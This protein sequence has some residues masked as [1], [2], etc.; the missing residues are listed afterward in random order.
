MGEMSL[1]DQVNLGGVSRHET[2]TP[3]YGWL[4]KGFEASRQDAKVFSS[5]DAIER[6]GVGK[7]MVRSIRSW[8]LA[9]KI[10]EYGEGES[11]KG[12]KGSLHPTEFGE[13]L[14]D[15]KGW[16]PFLEDIGS[17][18]LLHWQL[19]LPPFEETSWSLA[20]NYCALPTFNI[21]QLTRTLFSAAQRFNKLSSLSE[22]SFEKDA[23]CLIRMY[24][25]DGRDGLER[26]ESPFSQLGVIRTAEEPRTYRF[27][28]AG[29]KS[30]PDLVFLACCFSY[31]DLTQPAQRTLPLHKIVHD[32]NAPGIAF[33]LSETETGQLLSQAASLLEGVEFVESLGNRQLQFDAEPKILY[34]NSLAQYYERNR[35][36]GK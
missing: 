11:K 33:K 25:D 3:R 5:P 10:L 28:I 19:F 20:F 29:K 24:S 14:L 9:F 6:L 2:F 31:A 18:W 22:G 34:E 12:Q 13:Y 30:L 16:D 26:V 36:K 23:S 8:C 32:F 21:H 17:L 35:R 1:Y 15:E 7:N 4:K 27:N